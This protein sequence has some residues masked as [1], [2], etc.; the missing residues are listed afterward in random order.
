[1]NQDAPMK[2]IRF[3]SGGKTFRGRLN[4][5]GTGSPLLG[6]GPDDLFFPALPA[7]SEERLTVD[8]LLAP[9]VPPDILAIGLNYSLHA[10]E[11][12]KEV[13]KVP[14]LF[15]K[16]GNSLNHPGHP[17]PLPKNS[18]KVD[19]EGELAVVIGKAAKDVPRER[20]LE[21]VFGYTCA[22]DVSARD[23]QQ[24]R[25]LGGG[26]FTRGKS[27]DGFCPLGPWIVTADEIADPS[28]CTIRTVINGV[29]MQDQGEETMVFDIPTLIESVSSTMT[30]RPGTVLLTGTPSGVGFARNPPVW[31]QPGDVVQVEIKGI[32]TLENPVR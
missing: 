11:G 28:A 8:S 18:S 14:L 25:A 6:A 10:A 17:I 19:Y 31:L 32:G 26:Q 12:R 27:F 30:L 20:A 15:Q 13:P 4:P 2:L 7:F 9:V 24:D 5:D 23:W 29:V 21:Y 16:A 1:M 3:L 22:N